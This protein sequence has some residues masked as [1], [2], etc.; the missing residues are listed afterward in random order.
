MTN[1]ND[2]FY[3]RQRVLS[4]LAKAVPFKD[5]VIGCSL[6]AGISSL[7]VFFSVFVLF[8]RLTRYFIVPK[9]PFG[10]LFTHFLPLF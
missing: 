1:T 7:P 2:H 6:L 5:V 9:S 4:I 8:S 3:P 10:P